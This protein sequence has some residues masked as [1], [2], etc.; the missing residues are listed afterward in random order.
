MRHTADQ[1]LA[2]PRK[3]QSCITIINSL[4]NEEM[5]GGKNPDYRIKRIVKED[6]L[7]QEA[8]RYVRR[9]G[10]ES[11]KSHWF[12]SKQKFDFAEQMK[13]EAGRMKEELQLANLELKQRRRYRLQQLYGYETREFEF[14]LAD[15]GLSIKRRY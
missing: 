10:F 3:L 13:R 9:I 15:L 1:S 6:S 4:V 2:E 14:Q 5:V 8:V 12:E 7:H 11:M